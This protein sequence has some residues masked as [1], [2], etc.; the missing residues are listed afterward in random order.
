MIS[1]NILIFILILHWLGD[2]VFQT[3]W[4]ASNKSKSLKALSLHI[5][6]YTGVLSLGIFD[7][8]AFLYFA[9]LNGA[10]HFIIDFFT[11]KLSSKLYSEH[12]IHNFFVVIGFDQLLHLSILVITARW[13]LG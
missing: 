13:L 9:L 7:S 12:K 4:M 2:F 5:L 11:S 10:I 8:Q 3:H 6:T 1:V